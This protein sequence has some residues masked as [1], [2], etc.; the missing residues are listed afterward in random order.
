ME[1]IVCVLD[2]SGSMGSVREDARSGLNAF[3]KDQLEVR[4]ANLT[5][6]WFDH[7][8]RVGYEGKLSA[9]QSLDVYPIG[10]MTALLDAVGKTIAHVGRRFSHEHPEKVI[11][12]VLTDGH[13]NSSKEY[14]TQT[15]ADLIKEHREKYGWGVVFLGADQDAWDAAQHMGFEKGTTVS[16]DSADTRKG[17]SDY[18]ATVRSLRR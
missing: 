13:E 2:K 9:F 3:V 11:L 12:A 6:V 8:W 7:E 1:E 18:S 17:F 10:G 16:Y 15:V 5:V 4:D 14:T